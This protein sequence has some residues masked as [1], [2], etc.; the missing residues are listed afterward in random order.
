MSVSPSAPAETLVSVLVPVLDEAAAIGEC[1]DRIVAQTWR[2]LEVIVADGGS[3]DETRHIVTERAAVDRR[4]RL[5]DNPGRLQSAG[6]NRAL[7]V[8]SGEIIVRLDA[9]SFVD[10]DYVGRCATQLL[11]GTH[12][13]VGGRMV[14]RPG[15]SPVERAIASANR[16]SWGAG[17][18][19]F[20]RAGEAGPA[21]TVYLG[22][23]RRQW[24]DLAGGWAE[25]VG[26][27]E[28]YEL[29][30]RIRSLGGVVW[31]D[32]S[33]EVGYQPRSTYRA[34]ARQYFRYGRSKAAVIRRHPR[35]LRARQ[36]APALL[37]P[38]AL[39]C[40][41]PGSLG[42]AARIGVLA[43]AGG[44]G[45]LA[46]RSSGSASERATAG[47]AAAVMHWSWSTG[48]WFGWVRPLAHAEERSS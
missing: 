34:L 33:L 42:R 5:I 18:A 10:R 13:V 39:S 31:L 8:A 4:I 25:D 45:T 46:A 36:I 30:H 21:E 47:L 22:A 2:H 17:P 3:S 9:R 14:P 28:D 12:A 23:F 44:I 29:N 16:S 38:V 6:L 20:H 19:R 27:N 24:L 1:L 15:P 40:A 32:P 7:A 26:V 43:Y 37:V 41:M 48:A 35:S 11:E